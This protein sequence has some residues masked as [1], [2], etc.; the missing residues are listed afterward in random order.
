M[1]CNFKQW[2]IVDLIKT[3]PLLFIYTNIIVNKLI[4]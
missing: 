2:I 1:V 3:L 4:V